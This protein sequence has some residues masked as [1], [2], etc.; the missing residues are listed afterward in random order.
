[1]DPLHGRDAIEDAAAARCSP[2]ASR[3]PRRRGLRMRVISLSR[4]IAQ[5]AHD[6][7]PPED[8]LRGL[9]V[10]CQRAPFNVHDVEHVA[11]VPRSHLMQTATH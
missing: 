2:R 10:S 4:E 6:D 8:K 9:F 11:L 7:Q 3:R 1:M 5:A